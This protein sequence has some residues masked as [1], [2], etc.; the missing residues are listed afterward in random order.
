MM[1]RRRML[2]LVVVLLFAAL[3]LNL[4]AVMVAAGEP[5]G[6]TPVA[7]GM[8]GDNENPENPELFLW[9]RKVLLG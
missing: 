1:R 7:A 4:A 9:S 8:G 6:G 5:D 2:R 3:A